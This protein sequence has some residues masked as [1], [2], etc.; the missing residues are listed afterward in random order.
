MFHRTK[1]DMQSL[2]SYSLN[3]NSSC[4]P[5][6]KDCYTSFLN[7]NVHEVVQHQKPLS[8][9]HPTNLAFD[10]D[11]YVTMVQSIASE[12][13]KHVCKLTLSVNECK[14]RS[15]SVKET[16]FAKHIKHL[17]RAYLLH[18]MVPERSGWK[19][20]ESMRGWKG[21][22]GGGGGGGV[23]CSSTFSA[24]QVSVI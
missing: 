4:T 21:G 14:G 11:K 6:F 7:T 2:L 15:A 19:G 20:E 9:N 3:D 1:V 12:L 24:V 13:W 17:R 10:V 5:T 8:H 22:V 18:I 23:Q 16:S